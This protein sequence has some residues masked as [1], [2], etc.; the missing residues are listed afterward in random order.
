MRECCFLRS[1]V[2]V[3]GFI[4]TIHVVEE[5]AGSVDF[6]ILITGELDIN[7]YTSVDLI[8]VTALNM[9]AQGKV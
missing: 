3:I 4:N 7:F 6:F 2:I 1:T 8:T 5:S 9:S